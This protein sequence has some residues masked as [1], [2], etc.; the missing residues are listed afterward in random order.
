MDIPSDRWS[1]GDVANDVEW[2]IGW[3][4]RSEWSCEWLMDAGWSRDM[5]IDVMI[6]RMVCIFG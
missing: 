2:L 6:Y 3:G 4:E 1:V 5:L